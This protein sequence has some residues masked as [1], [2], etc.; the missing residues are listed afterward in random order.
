MT[1]TTE[2]SVG[3]CAAL[4]GELFAGIISTVRRFETP[5]ASL[6]SQ[7]AA[8][9][10][11]DA[12]V[13]ALVH[14]V[15]QRPDSLIVG[16]G[17]VLEPGTLSPSSR[18]M[19]WWLGPRNTFRVN[20]SERRLRRLEIEENPEAEDYQDFRRAE[21]WR[22]PATTGEAHLTGPYVDYFCT[23]EYTVTITSPIR[24]ASGFA[25][26][27][28]ADLYVADLER[29]LLPIL[30][31]VDH[32]LSLVSTAGRVLVSTEHRTATGSLISLE[33]YSVD[34]VAWGGDG[35][36][37]TGRRREPRLAALG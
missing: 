4:V 37:L 18:S 35:L 21:W 26:V 24:T 9:P 14:P 11:I 16:A 10:E 25:G 7:R 13:E 31:R 33:D 29:Y 17:I 28:G 8:V 32:P 19:F 23:D 6:L 2:A 3:T 22:I 30:A 20:A 34:S 27:V 5:L 15:L 1:K 36:L 12:Q